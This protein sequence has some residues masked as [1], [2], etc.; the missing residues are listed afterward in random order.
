VEQTELKTMNKRKKHSMFIVIASL[1]GLLVMELLARG[2]FNLFGRYD[3]WGYTTGS[4]VYR[5]YIGFASKPYESGRDRYAFKLDSNDDLHRDLTEKDV[6]EY[7]IF[8]LGGS[9]VDGRQLNSV[10]DTLPA[11]IEQL[12]NE[13]ASSNST[14]SVINGGKGGFISVQSLMQH[15]FYINYSLKP[16]FIIHFSG[17]NDSVGSDLVWPAGKISGV[18]D[19]LHRYA[20]RVSLNVNNMTSFYGLFN[21]TF[22]KLADYSAVVFLVHKTMNDPNSWARWIDDTAVLKDDQFGMVE[23]VEKHVRRYIFNVELS[24]NLADDQIPVVHFFQPTLLPYME[25]WLS[26]KEKQYLKQGLD[27]SE[28]FHGYD[29]RDAKQHYYFRIREEFKRLS[30]SNNFRF[31]T[32]YD[33]SSLFDN[34]SPAKTYFGDHVHYLSEGRAVI[35]KEIGKLILPIIQGQIRSTR[36][37]R[38]CSL[39][40]N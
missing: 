6:C 28:S 38:D 1:L 10:D 21:A 26:P 9:T 15:A 4:N 36:R 13:Q 8:M 34:K 23:W 40:N 14:F 33:M 5:P 2:A 32:V 3:G 30:D 19:N 25:P 31:A 20:E 35:A 12:L 39:D 16:D 17:S 11:R 7:R 37:F 22:R 18:E 24:A 27:S 29:R